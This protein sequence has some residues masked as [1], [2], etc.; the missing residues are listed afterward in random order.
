[1]FSSC[2]SDTI[3]RGR[4][5][6]VLHMPVSS[7]N[8]MVLLAFVLQV[9]CLVMGWRCFSNQGIVHTLFFFLFSGESRRAESRISMA[10]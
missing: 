9:N 6:L 8:G 7:A 5:L 3:E 1:V 4:V 10:Y 2:S